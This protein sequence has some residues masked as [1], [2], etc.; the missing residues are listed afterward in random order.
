[1]ESALRA[2]DGYNVDASVG[3][4][5]QILSGADTSYEEL[6]TVPSRDRLTF[7]NGF[8]V[9]CAAV[10]VDLRESSKLI[11]KY[12]RP[13][14]AKLY[15]AYISELIAI[16]HLSTRCVEV[17]IHGDAV[18]GVFDT[19]T[20][21]DIDLTFETAVRCRTLIEV[22]NCRLPKYGYEPVRAGVGMHYGRV[23]MVKAGYY[24]SGINDLVYMGEVVNEASAL[25]DHGAQTSWSDPLILSDVFHSNLNDEYKKLCSQQYVGTTRVYSSSATTVDM[26]TWINANCA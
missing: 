19:P 26:Q 10:W 21:P 14:L 24:G 4:I 8:Y 17:N 1:M 2:W 15:R 5:N 7:T 12:R 3:R 25:S 9:E 11:Q 20:K 16:M 18:W 6:K 23:L 13:S 22:L